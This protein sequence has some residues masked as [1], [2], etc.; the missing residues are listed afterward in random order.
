M[1]F[2]FPLWFELTR[3]GKTFQGMCQQQRRNW[4]LQMRLSTPH[5][6]RYEM[7]WHGELLLSHL[8]GAGLVPWLLT[9]VGLPDNLL[10]TLAM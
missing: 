1:V 7:N 6:Y 3:T 10:R 9:E 5:I 2:L 4:A 8:H